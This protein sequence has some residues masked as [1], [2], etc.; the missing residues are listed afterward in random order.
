M[1][2]LKAIYCL[3]K[4]ILGNPHLWAFMDMAVKPVIESKDTPY[5]DKAY[6]KTKSA[7]LKLF[8]RG[9]KEVAIPDDLAY[10]IALKLFSNPGA[11]KALLE[12]LKPTGASKPAPKKTAAK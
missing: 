8:G 6:E 1:K 2:H 4:V 5:A 9:A 10:E 3:I 12:A 7:C 11:K